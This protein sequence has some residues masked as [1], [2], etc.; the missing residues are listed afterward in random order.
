MVAHGIL[1]E[2]VRYFDR[3]GVGIFAPRCAAPLTMLMVG[4]C[5]H[6]SMPNTSGLARR[7][8]HFS[9]RSSECFTDGR[10]PSWG[11]TAGISEAT[12]RRLDAGGKF[13]H[14]RQCQHGCVLTPSLLP[15][16]MPASQSERRKGEGGEKSSNRVGNG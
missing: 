15:I 14:C 13:Y 3:L 4:V 1:W 12:L 7:G 5:R 11:A 8:A 10:S 16:E 6:T 2:E 9:Y